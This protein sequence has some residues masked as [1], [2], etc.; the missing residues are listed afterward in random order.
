MNPILLFPGQATEAV[1]MSTGWTDHPLWNATLLEAEAHSGY[2]LRTWMAEGP[3]EALKAQRHA[4]CAVLAHSVAL[5]RCQRAAG[6][7]LP[8]VATG[9]SMGFFSALVAADVVPLAAA[10]DL[11]RAT[12]DEAERRFGDGTMGMAFVI[13]LK[14][15]DVR[16]RLAG[17]EDLLLSNVN[18]TAQVTVSGPREALAAFVAAVRPEVMKA[19]LLPVR[20]PLH[21]DHMAP[22]LP[23]IKARLEAWLPR[24]PAFPLVSPMDGRRIDDGFEAWEEAIVSV[25]STIHWPQALAGLRAVAPDGA[26]AECGHGTQLANLTRWLDRSA[27]VAS[28][29]GRPQGS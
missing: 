19:D 29:Q 4:P 25:A 9:H 21:C 17:R 1:G 24:D 23:Y 12:E 28:L 6:M 11:L 2:A 5:Y 15:A 10:L 26:L 18:G 27:Q 7:V 20:L 3:V 22:L 8:A 14:E 13:G 16:A